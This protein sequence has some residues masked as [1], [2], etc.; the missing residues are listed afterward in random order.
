M[1][2]PLVS[3]TTTLYYVAISFHRRV[4]YRALSLRYACIL[5][6]YLSAKFH[7]FCDLHCWA[8]PWR[9]IAYP[10]HTRTINHSPSLFDVSGTE[11]LKRLHFRKK[12]HLKS[13]QIWPMLATDHTVL[14]ATRSR[15]IPAFTPQLQGITT[16]WLVFIAPTQ[17]PWR[18]GQ[19]ELTWVADYILR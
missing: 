6:G 8:S 10:Q 12:P 4:W 17:Y 15:T 13:A 7:F 3:V 19:A 18:D 5:L 1:W 11:E 9:K 2:R 14:P 16:L